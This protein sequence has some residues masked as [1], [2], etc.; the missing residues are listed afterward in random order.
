MKKLFTVVLAIAIPAISLGNEWNSSCDSELKEYCPGYESDAGKAYCLFRHYNQLS[1]WCRGNARVA[2]YLEVPV[3]RVS[4]CK[5]DIEAFCGDTL[6]EGGK[7]SKCLISRFSSLSIDCRVGSNWGQALAEEKQ[8]KSPEYR[9]RQAKKA[10]KKVAHRKE[11]KRQANLENSCSF[12]IYFYCRESRTGGRLE[13]CLQEHRHQARTPCR[14]ALKASMQ[15]HAG[16]LD[17]H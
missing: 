7:L 4:I 8:L 15:F 12:E 2:D 6:N 13:S 10:V 3:N 17:S 1:K 14:Q 9:A 5:K 16:R 11:K